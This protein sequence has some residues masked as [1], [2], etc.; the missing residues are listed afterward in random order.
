MYLM[1]KSF[2][3]VSILLSRIA[4]GQSTE[5]PSVQANGGWW[6]IQNVFTHYTYG[7]RDTT[8]ADLNPDGSLSTGYVVTGTW[9]FSGAPATLE[10]G[11]PFALTLPFSAFHPTGAFGATDSSVQVIPLPSPAALAAANMIFGLPPESPGIGVEVNFLDDGGFICNTGSTYP[12]T[13]TTNCQTILSI[14]PITI[15]GS[16][17]QDPNVVWLDENDQP[18]DDPSQSKKCYFGIGLTD[19][20]GIL[21]LFTAVD[22]KN[23]VYLQDF[24]VGTANP[25]WGKMVATFTDESHSVPVSVTVY[26]ETNDGVN[27]DQGVDSDGNFHSV[28]GA[29]TAP[30]DTITINGTIAAFDAYMASLGAPVGSYTPIHPPS[31]RDHDEN[32]D[33]PNQPYGMI[34]GPGATVPNTDENGDGMPDVAIWEVNDATL[35]FSPTFPETKV[36]GNASGQNMVYVFDPVGI[37]GIP[38][39]GDEPFRATGYYMTTNFIQAAGLWGATVQGQPDPNAL[40]ANFTAGVAAVLAA[41]QFPDEVGA[42]ATQQGA[43]AFATFSAIMP[44]VGNDVV[45]AITAMGTPVAGNILAIV[46]KGPDGAVGGGDDYPTND[47]VQDANI[48]TQDP[49]SGRLLFEVDNTC[50]PINTTIRHRS[51]WLNT[52]L[53][54]TAD[55]KAPLASKFE[56]KGNYP[57]PFNPSTSI[58]FSTE[59]FSNVKVTVYNMLGREILTLQDS[60]LNAGTYDTKWYGN[61]MNGNKVSSGM[62]FY[63]IRSDNRSLRGKMLLLK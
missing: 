33:T 32:P 57:N 52:A 53:L 4:F 11:S 2:I 10:D 8:V 13:T 39:N 49:V 44:T 19:T 20:D 41:W 46:Q 15:D 9:P 42:I 63:E 54:T 31:K 5:V 29:A 43:I 12:T 51:L 36:I 50:I 34:G 61:D 45:A 47:S 17:T 23:G 18:I 1:L 3:S 25:S 24:G 37:D 6:Q 30:A 40:Q 55:D 7:V 28:L 59:K 62:Y 26:W 14:P 16:W 27:E 48:Q 21:A 58:K 35:E 22:L 38:L 56:I 60:D